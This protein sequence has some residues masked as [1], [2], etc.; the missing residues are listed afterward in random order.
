MDVEKDTNMTIRRKNV[1]NVK[2]IVFHVLPILV[3][4][5]LKD[6]HL[7]MVSVNR[8]LLIAIR[9]PQKTTTVTTV[10]IINSIIQRVRNARNAIPLALVAIKDQIIANLVLLINLFLERNMWYKSDDR[11]RMKWVYCEVS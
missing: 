5:V 11:L 3:I 6:T 7:L 8:I 10:V 9:N 1:L 4:S 2:K